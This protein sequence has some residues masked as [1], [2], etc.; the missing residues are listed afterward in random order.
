MAVAYLASTFFTD[1]AISGTSVSGS[2]NSGST[3][4]DRV[5]IAAVSLDSSS[6][7][8]TL[9][10][11][12]SVNLT[13][14]TSPSPRCS[15]Y[16]LVNPPTG[17]NTLRFDS[18]LTTNITVVAAVFTGVDQTTPVNLSNIQSTTG[19]GTSVNRTISGATNNGFVDASGVNGGTLDS[20]GAGS[21]DGQTELGIAFTLGSSGGN[22]IGMSYG[23]AQASAVYDWSWT[24]SVSYSYAVV[25]LYATG[26]APTGGRIFKLAGEGGGLAGPSRGLAAEDVSW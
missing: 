22:K 16:I 9:A 15:I 4:S 13:L 26:A 5:L 19:T 12:N 10:Q 7:V 23:A 6:A 8:V 2:M 14:V 18:D 20:M 21:G 17:S 25:E 11:Y 1:Y 3:G 24:T